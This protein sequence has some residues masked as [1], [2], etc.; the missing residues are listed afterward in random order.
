MTQQLIQQLTEQLQ[1]AYICEFA[2]EPEKFLTFD[3]TRA[4]HMRMNLSYFYLKDGDKIT[5]EVL[6]KTS[7]FVKTM[8]D[9]IFKDASEVLLFEYVYNPKQLRRFIRQSQI[10]K[11]HFV[12]CTAE[13]QEET[14]LRTVRCSINHPS[15][16]YKLVISSVYQDFRPYNQTISKISNTV[17]LLNPD[18]D[19]L[20]DVYDDR[21]CD[22]YCRRKEDYH[23]LLNFCKE[24]VDHYTKMMEKQDYEIIDSPY[25]IRFRK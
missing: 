9:F 6:K 7:E 10:V 4:Y 14:M 18:K 16:L 12:F 15:E 22:I 25:G 24:R 2:Y 17:V 3:G 8:I 13:D 11:D 20:I 1:K 5:R 19:I 21:G 23:A